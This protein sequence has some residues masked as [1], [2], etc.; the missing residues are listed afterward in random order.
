[1]ES[2][3]RCISTASGSA[4]GTFGT[5]RAEDGVCPDRPGE[6]RTLWSKTLHRLGGRFPWLKDRFENGIPRDL[7]AFGVSLIFHG[8]ILLT[9]AVMGIAAQAELKREITSQIVDTSIPSFDKTEIQD[10]DQPDLPAVV[11][12]IGSS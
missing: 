7:P 3:N 11:N 12:A 8:A 1:M 6:S 10:I 2:M 5:V 9:L 4:S